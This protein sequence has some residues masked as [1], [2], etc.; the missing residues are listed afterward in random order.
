MS[1]LSGIYNRANLPLGNG[2]SAIISNSEVASYL[3][4]ERKHFYAFGLNLEP[5]TFGDALFRG[6]EGH[7]ILATYY[8]ALQS[9][10]PHKDAK[11]EAFEHL[12]VRMSE[13][14]EMRVPIL[15][16]L[17]LVLSHYFKYVADEPIKVIRVE[18]EFILNYRSDVGY[19]M[20]LDLLLEWTGGQRKGKV[21]LWDHKFVY[22]FKTFNELRINAQLPKYVS[23]L[24]NEG[25]H[26]D[27]AFLNQLRWRD[28]QAN[29]IDPTERFVRERIDPSPKETR[30]LFR[31]Q[32][33]TADRILE[34][35]QLSK[36]EWS[37]RSMRAMNELVC[38]N[39]SF[40]NLCMLELAGQ[41][42]DVMV[43]TEYQPN[44]YRY[45]EAYATE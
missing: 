12:T 29:A 22:N 35:R 23:V 41:S 31:E 17:A 3:Q 8:K 39:C 30:N 45:E 15:S 27:G 25:Y 6:I 32:I 37:N 20:R 26:I 7:S 2:M 10:L 16:H 21:D 5:R 40:F 34:L 38:K 18:D 11:R 13:S 1:Q 28:T 9:G 43:A 14:P 24:Q 42:P 33:I 44:T 36:R 4:C 19:G